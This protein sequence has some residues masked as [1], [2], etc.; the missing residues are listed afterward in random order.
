MR[1]IKIISC[2]FCS[3]FIILSCYDDLH[4]FDYQLA[5]TVERYLYSL[6]NG[7]IETLA[8]L[9]SDEEITRN[10][11]RLKNPN[12]S[13]FLKEYYQN[14]DFIIEDIRELTSL[15]F[16]YKVKIISNRQLIAMPIFKFQMINGEWKMVGIKEKF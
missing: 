11:K 2:I 13:S 1:K 9:M 4:A 6:K 14:C 15:N 7:D 8:E 12:Y 5:K 3:I 16:E 10:E